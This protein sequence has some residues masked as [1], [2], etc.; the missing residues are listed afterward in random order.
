M[1]NPQLSRLLAGLRGA[2]SPGSGPL[3]VFYIV[4]EFGTT[5]LY[6]DGYDK[7]L[8]KSACLRGFNIVIYSDMEYLTRWIR[9]KE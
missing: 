6:T 3:V 7:E 2:A 1:A 8:L 4:G 9:S 5:T